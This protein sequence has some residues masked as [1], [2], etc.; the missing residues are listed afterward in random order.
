MVDTVE[1][2][3]A[4]EFAPLHIM[5]VKAP[6][7]GHDDACKRS[8]PILS[9]DSRETRIN[10]G[11]RGNG[12]NV[13]VAKLGFFIIALFLVFIASQGEKVRNVDGVANDDISMQTGYA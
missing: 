11:Y 5:E 12:S 8:N 3:R 4:L 2:I 13:K 9:L 7:D 6:D 10:P 1:H